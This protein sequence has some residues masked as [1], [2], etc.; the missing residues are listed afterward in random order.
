[1]FDRNYYA[2][3]PDM[4]EC[5]SNEELRDRY[6]VQGLFRE[7][8]VVLNYTH[9]DR[10]VIDGVLVGAADVRLPEQTE[11][12]SA[13]GHPF[14]ERRELAIVNVGQAAGSERIPAGRWGEPS[15][16]GGAAVFLASDASNYV[17]GHILA[18]DG[19]WLAR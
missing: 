2:T 4:M 14:L 12:A 16:L 5:V 9:A 11:P 13:A 17:N 3:H 18:V 15:D 7:G 1:M 8:E 19:G 6:L 10:L